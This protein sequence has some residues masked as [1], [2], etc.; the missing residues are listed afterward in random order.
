MLVAS[1]EEAEAEGLVVVL[2]LVLV[3]DAVHTVRVQLLL[4]SLP[5][6]WTSASQGT[7]A[8]GSQAATRFLLELVVVVVVFVYLFLV[9][10]VFVSLA[11]WID[12]DPG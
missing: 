3:F 9:P 11:P 10:F 6:P 12:L 7:H 2:V 5:P 4:F 8:P 1:Y